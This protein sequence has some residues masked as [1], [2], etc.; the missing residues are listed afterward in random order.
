VQGSG[1]GLYL[2]RRLAERLG[3]RL[4]LESSQAGVGSVFRLEL[5]LG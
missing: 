5:P 4:S 2:G 1:I 3:G